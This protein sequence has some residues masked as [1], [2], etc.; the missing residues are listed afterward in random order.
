MI[1]GLKMVGIIYLFFAQTGRVTGF[2]ITLGAIFLAV[3]E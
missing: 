2:L 3:M 1:S